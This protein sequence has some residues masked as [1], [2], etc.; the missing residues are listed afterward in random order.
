MVTIPGYNFKR[1]ERD[2][3]EETGGWRHAFS[4]VSFTYFSVKG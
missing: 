4:G 2:F 3:T 1:F